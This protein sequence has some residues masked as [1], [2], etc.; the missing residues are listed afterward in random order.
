MTKVELS[1]SP[2]VPLHMPPLIAVNRILRIADCDWLTCAA[3]LLTVLGWSLMWLRALS[4]VRLMPVWLYA[5]VFF[6]G[7]ILIPFRPASRTRAD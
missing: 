4:V 1:G 5:S 2:P 3:L 6:L 7:L